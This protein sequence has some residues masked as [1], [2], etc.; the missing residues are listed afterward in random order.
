MLRGEKRKLLYSG[1]A[2]C[3]I[4]RCKIVDQ[5]VQGCHTC[6]SDRCWE[7]REHPYCTSPTA[8]DVPS[9]SSSHAIA[10]GRSMWH[11]RYKSTSSCVLVSSIIC[12]TRRQTIQACTPSNWTRVYWLDFIRRRRSWPEPV[13]AS[14]RPLCNCLHRMG[15][16]SFCLTCL[17]AR[18]R[19]RRRSQPLAIQVRRCSSPRAR[20]TGVN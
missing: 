12:L 6:K 20:L 14:A 4:I 3:R 17:T 16:M 1:L 13:E 10:R 11:L 9:A 8:A 2:M 18:R 7:T 15:P 5:G 19:Q